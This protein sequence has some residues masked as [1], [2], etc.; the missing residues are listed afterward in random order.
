MDLEVRYA[1][2]KSLL[3]LGGGLL[4]AGINTAMYFFMP[5]HYPAL[6]IIGVPLALFGL[7]GLGGK[8]IL[9]ANEAGLFYAPWGAAA[10]PWDV[11]E[12]FSVITQDRH[13]FVAAHARSPDDMLARLPRMARFNALFNRRFGRPP[14]YISPV[15][16]DAD[17]E[18]IAAAL[19][20]HLEAR[21]PEA[22][23]Q[24]AAPNP[25]AL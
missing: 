20:A 4:M 12:R 18:R 21:S 8:V 23:G 7:R 1:R 14:F 11:F 25:R 24:W 19:S 15:Q 3:F 5:Y 22:R 17:A 6:W 10:F 16:L 13:A 9:R 2:N